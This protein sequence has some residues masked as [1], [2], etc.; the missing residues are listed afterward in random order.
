[1]ILLIRLNVIPE[2]AQRLSKTN[3]VLLVISYVTSE[4][5]IVRNI[6]LTSILV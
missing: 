1:M 4:A 5:G 2:S 6:A 3:M